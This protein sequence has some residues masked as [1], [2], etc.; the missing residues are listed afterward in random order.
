MPQSKV[1]IITIA[2]MVGILIIGV[3]TILLLNNQQ[4]KRQL[5]ASE[6]AGALAAN[7]DTGAQYTD[8]AGNPANLEQYLGRVLIVTSWA[9][10]SPFSSTELQ[11]LADA[12]A[13][14]ADDDVV[15]IAINR[16]EAQSLAESY[17]QT[18]GVDEEVKLI[19][20]STDNYYKKIGGY[21]MPETVFYDRQG[22]IIAHERG[23]LT[24]DEVIFNIEQ[25]LADE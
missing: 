24:K 23:S 25:A 14:Y 21:T 3:I 10:W 5:A 18:I 11:L 20:D 2:I 15:L 8:F 9:S 16:A 7:K 6:A 1:T 19:V 17:L 13:P 12:T 22:N 4:E